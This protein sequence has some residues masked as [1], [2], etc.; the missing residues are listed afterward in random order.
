MAVCST[1]IKVHVVTTFLVETLVYKSRSKGW[2]SSP[3]L[4]SALAERAE[5]G[6]GGGDLLCKLLPNHGE[7]FCCIDSDVIG[8]WLYY[9]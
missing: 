8:S 6:E 9:T 7:Q 3:L 1:E 5:G 2:K 4:F